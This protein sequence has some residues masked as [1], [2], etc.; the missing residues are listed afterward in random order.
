MIEHHHLL[1]V[2]DNWRHSPPIVNAAHSF[3]TET[4]APRP[5]AAGKATGRAYRINERLAARVT[6]RPRSTDRRPRG[7]WST[8]LIAIPALAEIQLI[9]REVV[10]TLQQQR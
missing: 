5:A 4:P 6:P 8:A 3:A 1:R 2:R 10:A 7:R 9:M